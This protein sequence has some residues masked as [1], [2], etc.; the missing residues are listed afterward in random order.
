[1]S[2]FPNT[3]EQMMMLDRQR[4]A[5]FDDALLRNLR[6]MGSDVPMGNTTFSPGI[7]FNAPTMYS[8]VLQGIGGTFG[9]TAAQTIDLVS[10]LI[11]NP[12]FA[13]MLGPLPGYLS[14]IQ[15]LPPIGGAVDPGGFAYSQL[16]GRI[17]SGVEVP[18]M[19]PPS[20]FS[21]RQAIDAYNAQLANLDYYM[22][23]ET[24][25]SQQ[26]ISPAV[27]ATENMQLATAFENIS[28]MQ[29][30]DRN[31]KN[32]FALFN[33][34]MPGTRASVISPDIQ[35][36]LRQAAVTG[37]EAA[38][39]GLMQ[40]PTI[41]NV[42]DRQQSLAKNASA[43]MGVSGMLSNFIGSSAAETAQVQGI[44]DILRQV[45]KL[46]QPGVMTAATT[47]SLAN[48]GNLGVA[49]TS[50]LNERGLPETRSVVG[51][52]TAALQERIRMSGMDA[53]T[54][55]MGTGFT[56]MQAQG[57]ERT[58][59]LIRELQT[60]GM[61]N[62]GGVDIFNAIK[63]E[64][65]KKMEDAVAVQLEGFSELAKAGRRMGMQI[66]EITRNLQ[67]VYGGRLPQ[68]LR[69]QAMAE[70]PGVQTEEL[71]LV[72]RARERGISEDV[73]GA[74]GSRQ[75]Q[76]FLELEAQRRAGTTM[77]QQLEQAVELGRFAGIDAR[78]VMAM[79]T[80]ATQMTR[81]IGL[82]GE[83]SM[84]MTQ[85]ALQRVAMSRQMGEPITAAQSL[86]ISAG[87]AERGMR[88]TSVR[89]FAALK[90]AMKDGL[91]I[92][93][94]DADAL[95]SK[96]NNNEFVDPDIVSNLIRSAGGIPEAYTSE[97][98]MQAA[99]SDPET[100]ASVRSRFSSDQALS[101]SGTLQRMFESG[102]ANVQNLVSTVSSNTELA[103]MLGVEGNVNFTSIAA[104]FNRLQ[105]PMAREDFLKQLTANLP[106]DQARAMTGAFRSLLGANT[107][108][109]SV[110]GDNGVI[111]PA[112]VLLQE[113]AERNQFGGMTRAEIGA[114]AVV[115][116]KKGLEEA[117][118]AGGPTAIADA[119][120]G[121]MDR[122]VAE[123]RKAI[124]EGGPAGLS[125]DELNELGRMRATRTVAQDLTSG[126]LA[127]TEDQKQ[128]IATARKIDVANIDASLAATPLS[129]A[130][131]QSLIASK[132]VDISAQQAAERGAFEAGKAPLTEMEINTLAER[133]AAS[134]SFT[135]PDVLQG[136]A[137]TDM[138]KFVE[139]LSQQAD[140][141]KAEL[142]ALKQ[143]PVPAS[144]AELKQMQA[145]LESKRTEA[146]ALSNTLQDLRRTTD[147]Q[148]KALADTPDYFASKSVKTTRDAALAMSSEDAAKAV[149]QQ[150]VDLEQLEMASYTSREDTKADLSV[151][152]DLNKITQSLQDKMAKKLEDLG[153]EEGKADVM[154]T[155][156]PFTFEDVR[157]EIEAAQVSPERKAQLNKLV[158]RY[159]EERKQALTA[160]ERQVDPATGARIAP[161]SAVALDAV[162]AEDVARLDPQIKTREDVQRQL[163][164]DKAKLA[165]TE[166]VYEAIK[167]ELKQKQDEFDTA[168]RSGGER[169]ARVME[170]QTQIQQLEGLQT[171][172]A[173]FKSDSP[174]AKAA[175]DS[176]IQRLSGTP[177]EAQPGAAATTT[178]AAS[179]PPPLLARPEDSSA[180]G[181]APVEGMQIAPTT[182]PSAQPTPGS[183]PSQPAPAL[184]TEQVSKITE[185]L[186][187]DMDKKLAGIQQEL[188]ALGTFVRSRA[189][190]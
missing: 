116:I 52:I 146:Q 104:G 189:N 88:N 87:I 122:S 47:Q 171:T 183:A 100:M 134:T 82:T 109:L 129:P 44:G 123:A 39:A 118:G 22:R 40:D 168:S 125:Q 50:F 153:V 172:L 78:G 173:K 61:L 140:K 73:I 102:G 163:E 128:Q 120:K 132:S 12:A 124:S 179:A 8:Q 145:E 63:P 158:D 112:T 176:F 119:F 26:L 38:I 69:E 85:D 160:G 43:L 150:G 89:A 182:A 79:A 10:G 114:Q 28:R 137:G 91:P 84:F 67:A 51:Q 9:D 135:L 18:Q 6:L 142:D 164:V 46:D 101:V 41:R 130:E 24:R 166:S 30:Q 7:G 25:P 45:L 165:E 95:I 147:E 66:P 13:P 58:G 110:V 174:E 143:N 127:L 151:R 31:F 62:T 81:D 161:E 144:S 36:Q 156:T 92:S 97:R 186:K 175:I 113:E 5:S 157:K 20:N 33:E 184:G 115:N 187:N 75:R 19:A 80:T 188:N 94:G 154:A 96:F 15:G 106:E 77:M 103:K 178:P 169:S 59:Q 55:G 149:E 4:I 37:D 32:M 170:L 3:F 68:V 42:L 74:S 185:Y 159:M 105:T 155:L 126:Q 148:T 131:A 111:S 34:V 35:A 108:N 71:T 167:L 98:A 117:M 70:M 121:M 180:V 177:T 54:R 1:L 56:S 152:E 65:V 162:A 83:A 57:F 181:V 48:M 53:E 141:A 21:N 14:S 93:Q 2:Q 76:Q 49:Q 90:K 60:S 11:K 133:R 138:G 23:R 107:N 29:Q 27:D 16:Y 72:D 99:M 136:L 139:V 17:A 64:D 190:A 86:A